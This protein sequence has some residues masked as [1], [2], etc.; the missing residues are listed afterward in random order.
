[1][2]M[3]RVDTFPMPEDRWIV[4]E[5][6]IK[7]K[8]LVRQHLNSYN[9][10]IARKLREII[11]EESIVQ[12]SSPNFYAVITDVRIGNP[13]VREFDGSINTSITPLECRIRNLTYAAPVYVNIVL[14]EIGIKSASPEP[15]LL[16]EIP[17]MVR[18]VKDPTS[19][20]DEKTL[21]EIG[22]D[23]RDPGGYFIINGSERILVAQEDLAPNRVIVDYAKEGLNV[24]HMAKVVSATTGYRVPIILDRHKD[25]TLHISFPAVTGKIPFAVMMRALG[26]DS[27]YEI[28]LAVSPDQE[29]QKELIP[30]LLQSAE[31]KTSTDALEFIGNRVAIGQPR[32]VRIERAEQIIDRYFLPHLGTSKNDRLK[33]ALYLGYM[34]LKLIEFMLGRR[35]ADDKDHYRNKRLKLAGDLL[36]VQFRVAYRAFLKD[37]RYQLEKARART[38]KVTQISALVRSDIITERIRHAMATGN[39]VGNRVGVSQIL[40][41]TNWISVH[42]HLRRVVSPLSRSQPN[43][44]AR[45]LHGTQWGRICLFE[46][47]EGPNCGLVKNMALT[48]YISVGVDESI[49]LDILEKIDVPDMRIEKIEKIFNELKK[50]GSPMIGGSRVL[51]NG[52]PIGFC[53]DGEKLVRFLRELRRSGKLHYEVSI[54]HIKTQYV[55]EIYINTDA[56]RFLRPVFVVKD[57]KLIYSRE[58]AEALRRGEIGFEDLVRMGVVEY[59]DPDEEENAYIALNPSDLTKEHTHM[60]IYPPAIVGIAAATIPYAEH[61]Q[62][63]RNT[64]QSAMVKQALGIYAANYQIRTDTRSYLLHYPEKP[65][66][67]TK[68]LD[69]IGYNSKPAGH[70]MVVAVMSYTGYNMEDAV[71][72]NKSSVERGMARSTFFRLY[73][74]EERRYPGGEEDIIEIPD[75]SVHGYRGKQFYSKLGKE[76]IIGVEVPVEGGEILVGK[77][78]PSRFME[79]MKEF[80][81]IAAKRKDTSTGVRHGEKGIVDM[82][83]MTTTSEGHRLVKVRVRDLGIVEIGDKFASRHGQKGVVGMLIPQS[84]MPYTSEGITPDLIINPHALPSRMTL[85]QLMESIAGKVAALRGRYVD[86]TPFY[87]EDIESLKRELL[88]LGYPMDGT[89]P[90]YDG[91]TGELIGSPIFIGIVFYQKLHHMVANKIHARARGQVQILTKQPTEG[92]AREG[93]LRFGEMERDSLVGHGASILLKEKMLDASDKT[94]V[95]VCTECGHI[96]WFDRNNKKPVCPLHGDKSKIVPVSVSYA[97]KLLLQ[98]L[99]AMLIAPRLIVK[100]KVDVFRERWR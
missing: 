71:I 64:Y 38:R 93:G 32:E 69:V 81:V 67:Q 22:E 99:M 19:T 50:G 90:M 73:T 13:Q 70:N 45:D 77:T 36:A 66:A 54:A 55:D 14:V 3:Q 21:R 57:G 85:G 74:V 95:Y 16:C 87:G 98:E 68:F 92:R 61:N 35:E 4:I 15:I 2:S 51:I 48:A 84:D 56:G 9:D 34:A 27:D 91:R 39:W 5:R 6:F 78:S 49:V 29:I 76:G 89:E 24:T 83:I 20:M 100:E 65:L 11:E 43:F 1:M 58:H 41:R 31:I 96:G 82:V 80:G 62:S 60:E 25:G 75:P 46:T 33:K 12:T 23:P 94:T 59:L 17:V 37:F 86:A 18:S 28:A 40:D 97:F 79:E 53:R 52:R 47:P 72:L 26:L 30:S 44:E 10:F 7:E 88:L 42:S 63:P 8:G